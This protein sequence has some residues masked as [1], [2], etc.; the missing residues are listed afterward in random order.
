MTQW[1]RLTAGVLFAMSS[2]AMLLNFSVPFDERWPI[3]AICAV[4]ATPLLVVWHRKRQRDQR[5]IRLA[6]AQWSPSRPTPM[7]HQTQT[8]S[9]KQ[10]N[11]G[12]FVPPPLH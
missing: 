5:T 11:N 10:R 9:D 3:A 6:A 1:K 8:V 2:I 4:I 12:L 7:P